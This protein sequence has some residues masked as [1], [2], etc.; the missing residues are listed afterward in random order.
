MSE[1]H[2]HHPAFE[3][4]APGFGTVRL[5]PLDPERDA[6]V[7]HTWVSAERAAFWGMTGLTR[8]QVAGIY[9]HMAALDTHHAYLALLTHPG[10]KGGTPVGLLQTYDPVADRV[11]ECYDVRPGDI[12]IHVL[13]APA[14]PDGP[15]PGWTQAL[16]SA[17]TAYV[18]RAPGRHR[19]V[20]DPDVR[21]EKAIARFRRHGF[22]PG[23]AVVLPEIDLPDVHL[24]EKH[25]Q[26][27]FLTRPVAFQDV[28]PDTDPR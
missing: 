8:S 10:E 19:I 17:F 14:G 11:S 15:R 7:V 23:P 18:L 25:T 22:E 6:D 1:Q 16:L 3:H 13:L 12:G 5:R 4:P 2:E 28:L 20:V 21:N 26:L 24:P 27:A 9:A